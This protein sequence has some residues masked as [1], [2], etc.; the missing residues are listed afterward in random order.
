MHPVAG[1]LHVRKRRRGE[2]LA[3]LVVVSH[4][5]VVG[6]AAADEDRLA[7]ERGA[8]HVGEFRC[9]NAGLSNAL[10]LVV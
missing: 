2:S 1:A 4:G 7:A 5:Q 6:V 3:D 10:V 8:T 9:R